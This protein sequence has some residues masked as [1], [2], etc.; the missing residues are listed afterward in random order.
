MQSGEITTVGFNGMP[1]QRMQKL[2]TNFKRDGKRGRDRDY[3][4]AIFLLLIIV[5]KLPHTRHL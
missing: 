5:S 2:P 1:Q 3:R 4:I